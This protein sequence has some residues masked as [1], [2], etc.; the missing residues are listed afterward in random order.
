MFDCGFNLHDPPVSGTTT[1]PGTIRNTKASFL[2]DDLTPPGNGARLGYLFWHQEATTQ[3]GRQAEVQRIWR[4]LAV[5]AFAE[6]DVLR[7]V[8]S[9]AG[10]A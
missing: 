9:S 7:G 10:P 6:E 3:P 2:Q 1:R 8:T 4:T 5:A